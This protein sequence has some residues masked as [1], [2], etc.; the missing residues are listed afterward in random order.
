MVLHPAFVL[1]QVGYPPRRPQAGFIAQ[2]LRPAFQSP[3]DA[4]QCF[5]TETGLAQSSSRLLQRTPSTLLLAPVAVPTDLTTADAP[6]HP[7]TPGHLRLTVSLLQQP[8][9]FHPPPFQ[10]LKISANSRW[11]AHTGTVLQTQ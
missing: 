8:R 4:P 3:F 11:I 7:H 2:R 9:R 1:D 5:R 10:C 6:M